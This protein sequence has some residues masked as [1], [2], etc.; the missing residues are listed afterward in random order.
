MTNHP[1]LSGIQNF[2]FKTDTVLGKLGGQVTLEGTYEH[3]ANF[4]V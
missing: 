4:I 1:N 3:F 2:S